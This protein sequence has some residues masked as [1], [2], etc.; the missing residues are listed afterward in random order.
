M[1]IH[2]PCLQGLWHFLKIHPTI[3]WVFSVCLSVPHLLRRLWT[4]RNHT[5]QEG[6][7]QVDLE[8]KAIGY[9][10]N[11]CAAMVTN[12][13]WFLEDRSAIKFMAG[14][15]GTGMERTL[16]YW[17]PWQPI[18]CHGNNKGWSLGPDQD[19]CGA[20]HCIWRHGWS[21][22]ANGHVWWH[23]SSYV[24]EMPW[25]VCH[26]TWMP[27]CKCTHLGNLMMAGNAMF[28]SVWAGE[29]GGN[30]IGSALVF[31]NT[32]YHLTYLK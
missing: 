7:G 26:N 3:I 9:H 23:H 15:L 27:R 18:C 31:W 1:D 17:F 20:L 25:Q 21:H 29:S 22:I 19:F 30:P 6:W 5:W 13:R 12:K 32:F 2:S 4:D 8:P 16:S 28:V 10:G 24:M 14:R 11:Q